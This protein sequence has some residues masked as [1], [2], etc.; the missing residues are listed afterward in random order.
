MILIVE[1]NINH[2]IFIKIISV[3]LFTLDYLLDIDVLS[4]KVYMMK[5]QKL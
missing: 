1:I 5:I 4:F 3:E 2:G